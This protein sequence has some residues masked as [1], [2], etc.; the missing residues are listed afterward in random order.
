MYFLHILQQKDY[1]KSVSVGLKIT[2]ADVFPAQLFD[3]KDSQF[4]PP[5]FLG[6]DLILP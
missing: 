3:G 4:P 5:S 6:I 1:L 2:D